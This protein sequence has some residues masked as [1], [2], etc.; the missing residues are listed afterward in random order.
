MG[1][2]E[3]I[4]SRGN[5]N[6]RQ[7]IEITL[8]RHRAVIKYKMRFSLERKKQNDQEEIFLFVCFRQW[9]EEYEKSMVLYKIQRRKYNSGN[10]IG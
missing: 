10:V 7:E 9:L 1:F 8:K 5:V 3:T 2:S 4:K 6:I